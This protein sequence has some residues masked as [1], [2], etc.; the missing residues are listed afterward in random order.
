MVKKVKGRDIYIPPLTGKPRPGAVY[1][2]K[3]RTD[4]QW[5]NWR[6]ASSDRPLPEWMHKICVMMPPA[7]Q[8]RLLGHLVHALQT[9]ACFIMLIYGA[10]W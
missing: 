2:W 8:H 5:H 1:N 3:W 9:C 10:W 4:W 7:I 6:S